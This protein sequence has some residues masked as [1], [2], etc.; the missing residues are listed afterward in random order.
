MQLK[1]DTVFANRYELI[2]LLGRGGF[3]EV[4]LARN[5][6]T[7]L[8][9]ALKV[10]A[11][12]SGMDEDG[13]KSFIKELSVVHDLH[14]TNLLTPNVLDQFENQP[15]LVLPYCPNGSLVKRVGACTETEAWQIIRQVAAGL[16]YLHANDIIHQDIKPDNILI[17]KN[18]N[19]VITDFGI[20]LRARSTLRK[21]V[22]NPVQS[23]TP[24]YIA[25]ERFSSEPKPLKASD[26]WSL[27][28]TMYEL[29]EGDVP[30]MSM[31]GLAQKNGADMPNLHADVSDELKQ[32]I[33]S[34]LSLDPAARPTA[35]QLVEI[36]SQH[37]EKSSETPTIGRVTEPIINNPSPVSENPKKKK[38][39]W[40]LLLFVVLIGL[41]IGGVAYYYIHNNVVQ[42]AQA[43]AQA[44]QEQAEQVEQAER[45]RILAERSAA[46][47]QAERERI[48]AEQ[49]AAAEQ[50][51][52]ERIAAE[53]RAAQERAEQERREAEA[54]AAQER[55]EAEA[56]AQAQAAQE[57]VDLGLPSG[58]LWKNEDEH[59][60][61]LFTYNE[62]LSVYG[63]K[64]PTKEQIDELVRNCTFY[65]ERNYIKIVSKNNGN[66]I[67]FSNKTYIDCSGVQSS[68]HSH[69]SGTSCNTNAVGVRQPSAYCLLDGQHLGV[70]ASYRLSRC[71]KCCVHLVKKAGDN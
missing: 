63:D 59:D 11:P 19:Y 55:R 62:A 12:G 51:E 6:L 4:W 70:Y 69:W 45:E 32:T 20:S 18:G 49:R 43:K 10:Y 38:R 61:F 26:I 35:A 28:I 9:D 48:E 44:A 65:T 13:L 50:A 66:W 2:R 68:Y 30:F 1:P 47:E 42:R 8:E 3:A 64:L 27:G 21:S 60:G 54:R 53:Q 33:I 23:G 22:S 25:P 39:D 37:L 57:Y 34:M 58:T 67:K 46:L 24:A 36:A 7:G 52:Q 16:A 15:Y 31:G 71:C 56:R 5:N 17:D 29:L 14:H 40:I 41:M